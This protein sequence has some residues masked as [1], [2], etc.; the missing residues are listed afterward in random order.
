M[1]TPQS[2]A[3]VEIQEDEQVIVHVRREGEPAIVSS[4]HCPFGCAVLC[5]SPEI[6]QV[7]PDQRTPAQIAEIR[8][9]HLAVKESY[10]RDLAAYEAEEASRE[11]DP[12]AQAA[13]AEH[14]A[15]NIQRGMLPP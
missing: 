1:N 12:A 3:P 6:C 13:Y 11:P 2:A 10:E 15:R 8:A 5:H 14:W 4:K 9:F 7:P